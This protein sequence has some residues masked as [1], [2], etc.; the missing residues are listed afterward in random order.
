MFSLVGGQVASFAIPVI[1]A[2]VLDCMLNEPGDLHTIGL[3]CL[4]M[5]GICAFSAFCVWYRAF[6]FNCLSEKIAVMLRY[7]LF[8]QLIHKAISFFDT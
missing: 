3:Y 4:Y 7:D 8:A 5:A 6:T 2:V 1:I